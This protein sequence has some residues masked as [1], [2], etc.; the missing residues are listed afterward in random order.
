MKKDTKIQRMSATSII[1]M[2]VL[3]CTGST[4]PK[5]NGTLVRQNVITNVENVNNVNE[6]AEI[7]T[8]SSVNDN[9]TQERQYIHPGYGTDQVHLG[10]SSEDLRRVLGKP[11]DENSHRESINV[12]GEILKSNCSYTEMHWFPKANPNGKMKERGNGIFAY[13]MDDRVYE[14]SFSGEKS[15]KTKEDINYLSS[16]KDLKNKIGA[17]VYILSPSAN[18][19]NNYE[20]LM[21]MVETEKGVAFELTNS[22][23]TKEKLVSA[24]YVFA[25]SGNFLPWGCIS[26]NQSF[27]EFAAESSQ[28]K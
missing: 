2:F 4:S 9:Y 5:T 8:P 19:A 22:Y 13:L 15:Y 26:D 3:G 24:I 12:N 28:N 27:K 14:I 7:E 21:Y 17:P 6:I 25:P 11:N 1:V 23:K 16:L 10:M 20:D 18:H